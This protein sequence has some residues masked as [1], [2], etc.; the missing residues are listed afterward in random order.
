MQ[1]EGTFSVEAAQG[2][3]VGTASVVHQVVCSDQTANDDREER[4][5][6]DPEAKE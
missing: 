2:E 5:K 6:A 1:A 3:T 4:N